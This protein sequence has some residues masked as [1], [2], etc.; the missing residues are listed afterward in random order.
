MSIYLDNVYS[1]PTITN[2]D[3]FGN[4]FYFAGV[5]DTDGFTTY[6]VKTPALAAG[7]WFADDFTFAGAPIPIPGAVWLLG[8]GLIGIVGIRKKFKT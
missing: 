8:S 7:H 3:S 6:T 5:I 2:I 1:G 4:P